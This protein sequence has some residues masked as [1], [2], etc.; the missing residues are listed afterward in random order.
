MT[1]QEKIQVELIGTRYKGVEPT[2][3]RLKE[4]VGKDCECYDVSIA[5]GADDDETEDTYIKCASFSFADSP[6]IVHIY[7][8]DV[9]E[10][11]GY[12][13]IVEVAI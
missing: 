1:T 11:I 2:K 3:E 9:T 6:I 10:E 12:V 5:D 8:G 13:D 4:L 7:Y